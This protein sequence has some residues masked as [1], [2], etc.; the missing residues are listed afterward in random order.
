MSDKESLI[1]AIDLTA[2]QLI[3]NVLQ[4]NINF[5]TYNSWHTIFNRI[6]NDDDNCT[7]KDYEK[8]FHFNKLIKESIIEK[9]KNDISLLQ[10]YST[11][12]EELSAFDTFIQVR[13]QLF[14]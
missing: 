14:K 13:A 5:E 10:N 4:F 6:K 1:G 3:N 2:E 8:Y 9:V 12:I 11:F 7:R